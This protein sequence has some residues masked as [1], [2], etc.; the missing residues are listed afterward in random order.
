M[1]Q[2]EIR[3]HD[4]RAGVLQE[5]AK[6]EYMFLYDTSYDGPAISL[7]MPLQ[8]AP[9]VFTSF[10]PFFDGLLPEGSQLDGLLRIRKID[11][12]DYFEQL[13]ATGADM[14]G[15]VTAQRLHDED[16]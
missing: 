9:Y 5:K 3:I 8:S 7:T 11:K 6:D 14:I 10:P 4:Q 16:E 15:A 12:Y 1:K 2:A 13:I